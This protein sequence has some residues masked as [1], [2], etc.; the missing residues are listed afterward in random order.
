M[1]D[2]KNIIPC[3]EHPFEDEIFSSWLVRLAH[4]HSLK[5]H[6]FCKFLFKTNDIWNRDIDKLVSDEILH[7][8]AS[9]TLTT[10]KQIESTT[11]RSYEGKLYLNHNP[12]GNTRWLMPL[13]VYHRE[14][15]N[16]GLMFCPKCLKNDGDSPYF[17]KHW[18]LSFSIICSKCGIYLHDRCPKC[19]KPIVFFRT[20]LGKKEELPT[21]SIAVCYH[22]DFDLRETPTVQAPVKLSRGQRTF[23]RILQEGWN[24]EVIYPH[25]YFDAVY[26][27]LKALKSPSIRCRKLQHDL[28]TR[29]GTPNIVETLISEKC[30]FEFLAL[31]KRVVL[32][33]QIWWLFGDLENHFIPVTKYHGMTSFVFFNDMAYR[34]FW[35]EKLVMEHLFVSNVNR[36]FLKESILEEQTNQVVAPLKGMRGPARKI[37]K[38]FECPRC[39]SNWIIKDGRKSGVARLKCRSCGKRIQESMR[40]NSPTAYHFR[41]SQKKN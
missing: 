32:L 8:L 22:C 10:F 27:V 40:V 23:Y 25:L 28:A 31:D 26:Q 13:G 12:N 19:G 29:F 36:K 5:V 4:R 24:K 6:S 34:P 11:L 7:I 9:R 35:F 14:H 39:K 21:K 2:F 15:K 30:S 18:R 38:G 20:E 16:Y 1:N 37:S 17:R 33:K 41:M 3:T